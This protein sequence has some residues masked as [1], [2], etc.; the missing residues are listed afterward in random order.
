MKF[1]KLTEAYM[2]VGKRV[3]PEKDFGQVQKYE[4]SMSPGDR[5]SEDEHGSWVHV[6]DYMELL[7]AY[8]KLKASLGK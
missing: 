4:A 3:K 2:N 6:T 5:P 7:D 1:D 8:N